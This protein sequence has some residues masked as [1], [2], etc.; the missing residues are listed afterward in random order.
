MKWRRRFY[1]AN[2]VMSP[3]FSLAP[4]VP[5]RTSWRLDLYGVKSVKFK[6]DEAPAT[7]TRARL[8]G[9]ISRRVMFPFKARELL[10]GGKL[11]HHSVYLLIK[12]NQGDNQSAAAAAEWAERI[13]ASR[14]SAAGQ[15]NPNSFPFLSFPS[16][17]TNIR[18]SATQFHYL[19]AR[20]SLGWPRSCARETANRV[21]AVSNITPPAPATAA[22]TAPATTRPARN[23]KLASL[24]AVARFP[25][26]SNERRVS[27]DTCL[28]FAAVQ[29]YHAIY[30]RHR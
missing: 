7:T 5:A 10:S 17:Q 26:N 29:E 21:P 28:S 6:G 22:A 3:C 19:R 20:F 25:R 16:A 2:I 9:N 18:C 4:S 30:Q 13:R 8:T 14:S 11:I 23:D 15:N 27:R 12:V 24:S 1:C